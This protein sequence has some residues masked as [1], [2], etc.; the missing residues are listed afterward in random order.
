MIREAQKGDIPAI[1]GMGC[2]F[3]QFSPYQVPA[4]PASIEAFAEHC[5]SESLLFVLEIDGRAEGFIAG[6]I[7]PVMGNMDYNVCTESAWWVNPEHRK[8]LRG[9]RLK[10]ALKERAREKGAD[11]VA[12]AYMETSMPAVISKIYE[13]Q[14]MEKAESLYLERL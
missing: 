13:M 12:M 14:G 5:L 1:V 9:I 7:G 4:D 10:N 2:E 8:G 11:F 3:W 6:V